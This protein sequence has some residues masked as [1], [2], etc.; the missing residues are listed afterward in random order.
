[1]NVFGTEECPCCNDVTGAVAGRNQKSGPFPLGTTETLAEEA[2]HLLARRGSD[3][4][5]R[6]R[7]AGLFVSHAEASEPSTRFLRPAQTPVLERSAPGTAL[8][9]L[10]HCTRPPPRPRCRAE[11]APPGRRQARRPRATG[12]CTPRAGRCA[13]RRQAARLPG[14]SRRVAA[15]TVPWPLGGA[16]PTFVGAEKQGASGRPGLRKCTDAALEVQWAASQSHSPCHSVAWLHGEEILIVA[17]SHAAARIL[18]RTR[19]AAPH[20]LRVQISALPKG[21]DRGGC[22]AHGALLRTRGRWPCP[23]HDSLVTTHKDVCRGGGVCGVVAELVRA[24]V[25]AAAAGTELGAV[26]S[27][28]AL[29]VPPRGAGGGT[30]AGW[31]LCVD[32]ARE[33]MDGCGQ[34]VPT[35]PPVPVVSVRCCVVRTSWPTS[36]ALD[37][38][39]MAPDAPAL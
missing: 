35:A 38:E 39:L 15:L 32:G 21:E 13:A 36:A 11:G 3:S 12:S 16:E 23:Q 22:R 8:G 25:R 18:T 37:A 1:M 30:E 5:P 31:V 4:R 6:L 33:H 24:A 2:R 26:S 9:H 20:P 27:R 17:L 14:A 29:R 34:G 10:P 19:G 7:S 28:V